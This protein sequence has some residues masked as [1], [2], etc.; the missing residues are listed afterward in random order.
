MASAANSAKTKRDSIKSA[1]KILRLKSWPDRSV[2]TKNSL[3]ERKRGA[4]GCVYRVRGR[5][6]QQRQRKGF[7]TCQEVYESATKKRLKKGGKERM[8]QGAALLKVR[9]LSKRPV[10]EKGSKDSHDR[11][12]SNQEAERRT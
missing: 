5:K 2:R 7:E 1:D 11:M 10:L 9:W 4:G 8:S 6:L 12:A 3:Q